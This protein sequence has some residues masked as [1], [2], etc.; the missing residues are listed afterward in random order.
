[1]VLHIILTRKVLEN[2]TL[3]YQLQIFKG[4]INIKV[5]CLGV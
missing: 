4:A 5:L 2:L 3:L 1:M